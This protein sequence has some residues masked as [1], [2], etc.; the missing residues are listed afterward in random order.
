MSIKNKL[1]WS[2]IALSLITT[3]S[4]QVVIPLGND[5]FVI[6]TENNSGIVTIDFDDFDY[7]R[8]NER[9]LT[10]FPI[11]HN[12]PI[13]KNQLFYNLELD[14]YGGLPFGSC[15]YREETLGQTISGVLRTYTDQ[16]MQF[17]NANANS[18]LMR[19]WDNRNPDLKNVLLKNMTI[20]NAFRTRNVVDGVIVTSSSALPHTDTFQLFYLGSSQEDPEWLVIQDTLIKN[21]DNSLMITGGGQFDAAVYQNLTAACDDAFKADTLE[22]ARNDYRAYVS[23]DENEVTQN[24]RIAPCSNAMNFST[25]HDNSTIWLINVQANRVS[26][27]NDSQVIW[28]GDHSLVPSGITTRDASNKVV[29]HDPELIDMFTTIEQALQNHSR[30]P[31]IEYSCSGW[32]Y[33]PTGCETQQGYL[34]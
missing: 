4:A 21:S 14:G 29:S 23:Q 34:Q 3:V 26:V 19:V 27:P 15:L 22:R 9:I 7:Q 6:G 33:P 24:V 12:L 17:C 30:P 16:E 11:G 1:F 2:V 25:N 13:S 18:D 10:G 32:A 20:K 28:V 8:I 31:Y 5:F